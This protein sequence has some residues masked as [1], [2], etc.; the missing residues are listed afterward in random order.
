MVA[1]P[2]YLDANTGGAWEGPLMLGAALAAAHG[3]FGMRADAAD[4]Y[5]GEH[6]AS[7]ADA[8][9]GSLSDDAR[10]DAAFDLGDGFHLQNDLKHVHAKVLDE[11]FTV[12]SAL[13]LFATDTSVPV[14][15]TTH[16]VRR[17][18]KRGKATIYRR[19]EP[20][21]LVS[22]N[23]KAESFPI[24]HVVDGFGIDM[25]SLMSSRFAGSQIYARGLR[26]A[27]E[28][29]VDTLNEIAWYGNEPAGLK[30]VLTFPWLAKLTLSTSFDRSVSA[31]AGAA[32]MLAALNRVASYPHDKSKGAASPN[33][34]CMSPRLR[35]IVFET[36]M[37][38]TGK[39]VGKVFLENHA[40][41]KSI[42]E[43][44]ELQEAGPGSTDGILVWRDSVDSLAVVMP[45]GFT[46]LP[47]QKQGFEE[48]VYGYAST[49][50][51]TMH[52][53]MNNALAWVTA[54]E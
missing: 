26:A 9:Y 13:L 50:G 51:V 38:D 45:Q 4:R 43:A 7:R 35:S 14:G 49:G 34:M 12:P 15:A 36:L 21:K 5:R 18:G 48:V 37:P 10:R 6:F 31:A 20:V 22:V 41:I 29:V 16:E 23:Q 46:S 42:D 2:A 39:S 17:V 24:R 25:F 40:T 53:A 8:I 44:A 28:V 52:N 19:G 33:R 30:G 1:N 32:L 3:L 47:A 11:P 27:R 54:V